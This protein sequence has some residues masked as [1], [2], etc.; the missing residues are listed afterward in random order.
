MKTILVMTAIM[1]CVFMS[2]QQKPDQQ[3][4]HDHY[5]HDHHAMEAQKP[6]K[7]LRHVVLF[8]FKDESSAEDIAQIEKEFE[9]LPSKIDAIVDFEWGTNNSP[10]GLADGFTHCFLVTFA[11]EKGR[12]TYLPHPDHEA[13][14]EIARP[15]FDKV[16][17]V[18]YW[19]GN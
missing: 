12:E 1:C 14:V 16:L 15:H 11:D 7:V 3:D 13:F 19:T 5:N 10:E 6:E 17:V 4:Q 18:D 9:A 2:C 8:K